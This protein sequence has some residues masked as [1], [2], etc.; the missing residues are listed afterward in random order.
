[1]TALRGVLP[2]LTVRLYF[3]SV[4]TQV[5]PLQLRLQLGW[6]WY[7]P[8][9]HLVRVRVRVRGRAWVRGR[10]RVWVRDRAWVK[11]RARGR[12]R[13]RVR[14][15]PSLAAHRVDAQAGDRSAGRQLALRCE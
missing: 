8:A 5:G 11:I 12:V 15:R 10:I 6:R 4:G 14:L 2:A 13:V 7:H 3:C 1:L 9:T